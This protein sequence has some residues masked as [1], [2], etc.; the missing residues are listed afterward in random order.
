MST[1]PIDAHL[2]AIASAVREHRGAVVVAEPGAGKTTR[3]PGMLLDTI[4][5]ATT[6]T[7]PRRIAA[8]MAAKQ[9]AKQRGTALGQEVGY[10]LRFER[11]LSEATRLRFVTEGIALRQWHKRRSGQ[12][13]LILDEFHERHL[14]ADMLLALAAAERAK[15]DDLAI[16]VMSAT[17]DPVAVAA[18]LGD[19]PIIAS[20]GRTHPVEIRYQMPRAEEG[21]AVSVSRALRSVLA[22]GI[23][24]DVL[25]F[26]PGVAEIRQCADRLQTLAQQHGLSV[27]P[28]HG[29]LSAAEQDR[30]L[31][32]N[33]KRKVILATNVAETSLTIEGVTVVIDSGTARVA[34]HSPW[35]GLPSLQVEA[36]SRASA[37]QRMGRAGRT[38]PGT[39]VRLYSEHELKGR[40]AFDAPEIAR[41]D[42]AG[43][44][45]RLA[46]NGWSLDSLDWLESP[47]PQA[48]DKAMDLLRMLGVFEEGE[49]LTELGKQM[50]RLPLH[51]RL[52][53]LALAALHLKIPRSG[54]LAAAVLGERPL[55]RR[56]APAPATST[57]D[58]LDALDTLAQLR[59]AKYRGNIARSLGADTATARNIERVADQIVGNLGK[60]HDAEMGLAELDEALRR[61]LL[62]AFPDR[63]GRRV[64]ERSES[65]LLCRGGAVQLAQSSAVRDAEYLLAID[66]ETRKT[67]GK[68][69][70]LV[71]I[72]SEIDPMWLLDLD[73][74]RDVDEHFFDAERDR[75]FRKTGIYYGD[76]A[77]DEELI[78]DPNR[79][80]AG[81]CRSIL[82][83]E[84]ASGKL[85]RVV[86]QEQLNAFRKR[87][88][89]VA[90]HRRDID[91]PSCDDRSVA[92][93]LLDFAISA[94]RLSDLQ[95][96]SLTEVLHFQMPEEQRAALARLAPT[97]ITLPGRNR[98][99]VN[100]ESDR[101][102][103]IQSRLQD[104]FGLS[105]GPCVCDGA[106]ALTMHLLAPN[107]RAVQVTTDLP[108]FWKRHYPDLR[109]Q[110]MRRYPRHKWPEDP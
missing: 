90:E 81:A 76:I 75:V 56:D 41:S 58:V 97:H 70:T 107:R 12:Q 5:W 37:K 2:E 84:L 7:Q 59:Q 38:A 73:W 55:H 92:S 13:I 62:A 11:K 91:W 72:A 48:R 32:P 44:A 86:D 89:F 20:E 16:V 45:L 109:R 64:R 26:L 10:E 9:V 52:A 49:S 100:Y 63:A 31:A 29:S 83:E 105:S 87:A 88:E 106:V 15:R 40:R 18:F 61:A 99:P 102:P 28:L 6:C 23:E 21:T 74:V 104:F 17:L 8:R 66:V 71:R 60:K 95:G 103:W 46:C 79:L 36:I 110:L 108:G 51:P 96:L 54:A 3:V 34:R 30:V 50:G 33:P 25:T 47:P 53:R 82:L 27:L 24:G 43:C 68:R 39:C 1:L 93:A 80:D 65:V 98:V 101:A 4:G 42:L 69:G 22:E 78:V 14:D 85:G 77:I 35:T 57:S 67:G 19:V 94:T